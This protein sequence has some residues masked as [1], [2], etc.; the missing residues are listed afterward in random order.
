MNICGIRSKLE[1]PSYVELV[2]KYDVIFLSEIKCTHPF[3]I[4]GYYCL[5]STVIPG[6][7]N[8]GGIAVLVHNSLWSGMYNIELH[9]DQIWFRLKQAPGFLFAALYVPHRDSPFFSHE[10][11]SII[12][13]HC[14]NPHDSVVLM[15]DVNARLGPLECFNDDAKNLQYSPN[16]DERRNTNGNDIRDLM[17]TA[18]LEPIN[19]LSIW[20][21]HFR[22]ELTFRKGRTWISQIDWAMAS[23]PALQHIQAFRVLKDVIVPTDHAPIE[24]II[25]KFEASESELLNRASDLGEEAFHGSRVR[26]IRMTDVDNVDICHPD[27]SRHQTI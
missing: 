11:F 14:R 16:P 21:R 27:G 23:I 8:R 26:A 3:R 4:A 2:H 1:H 12:N 13:E 15:G 5:R 18:S 25:S 10:S 7:E 6:E 17:L 19:G 22:G 9:R 20:E 24:L